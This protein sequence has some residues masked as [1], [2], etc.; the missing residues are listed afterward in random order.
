M[1]HKQ[2]LISLQ[3]WGRY[4]TIESEL[5]QPQSVKAC[6]DT[7]HTSSPIIPRGLGRSYGDSALGTRVLN[8]RYFNH[9]I[10]FDEKTGL[11]TCA[12]GVSLDTIL[13]VFVPRGWFLS[14]TPGTRYVTVGG[15]IASDVHGKNHHFAGTFGQHVVSMT[16]LLGNGDVITISRNTH[17]ELFRATCGGMGLTGIILSAT[18]RLIRIDSSDIIQSTIKTTCLEDTL[19]QFEIHADNPYSV[20]WID[21]LS[22]GK[23]L[24]RGLVMFGKHADEG[25]LCMQP[26]RYRTIPTYSPGIVNPYSVKMLNTLY[27]NKTW[28][29][30]HTTRTSLESFF[31]PLDSIHHWNRLYGRQGFLQYQIVLPRDGG[32]PGL[33]KI[34]TR[35]A[36]V[37]KSAFLAVLKIFGPGN[38]HFLSFPTEGYTLALDFKNTP[39]L[40][41][42][43]NELDTILLAYGGK[44]YLA[45]DARM[46]EET[47]KKT[48]PHWHTFVDIRD[49]YHASERFSSLQATRLGI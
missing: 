37:K 41:P 30:T 23:Q 10:G 46:H 17:E 22:S 36:E 29:R 15:A 8:T 38:D 27:Y 14:V 6:E 21:S 33:Q 40:L 26:P 39:S 18:F 48:Y 25:P 1:A 2:S 13:K 7:L 12:A 5:F 11:L 43:L 3:S 24:G 4:P 32:L 9:F 49:K 19:S 28:R 35:C 47:F 45:K 34:L 44:I 20:A 42:F 16:L 31:Y